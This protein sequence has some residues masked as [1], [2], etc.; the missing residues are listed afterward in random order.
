MKHIHELEAIESAFER[1]AEI[2][3]KELDALRE[4][5]FRKHYPHIKQGKEYLFTPPNEKIA[6]Y[7]V[8]FTG[9]WCTNTK[10]ITGG[11]V[12][13]RIVCETNRV[14]PNGKEFTGDMY[15]KYLPVDFLEEIK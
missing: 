13:V 2:V 9:N 7:K 8:I 14:R 10:F 15:R 12:G 11:G 6:P 3:K 4:S 5:W 1:M